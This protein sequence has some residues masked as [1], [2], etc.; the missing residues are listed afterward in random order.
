MGVPR[1]RIW[2][3]RARDV[4]LEIY[5][6]QNGAVSECSHLDAGDVSR[7]CD[8]GQVRTSIEGIGSDDR[9]VRTVYGG[10]YDNVAAGT[11]I[12]DY[13]DSA[14]G[15]CCVGVI[16]GQGRRGAEQS[17]KNGQKYSPDIHEYISHY[18][19]KF[20]PLAVAESKR[21]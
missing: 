15:I 16:A 21:M 1:E 17:S 4:A 11:G 10:W 8:A 2:K 5:I 7:N 20:Y 14:A 18:V 19:Q 9:D 13:G 6:R 3:A 12:V